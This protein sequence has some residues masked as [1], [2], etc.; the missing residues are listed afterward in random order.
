MILC[1]GEAQ[2]TVYYTTLFGLS[3]LHISYIH[4]SSPQIDDTVIFSTR[5]EPT[6]TDKLQL[7][8][9]RSMTSE[10]LQYTG[11]YY[12]QITSQALIRV[13]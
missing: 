5:D 6:L 10:L 9:I 4:T 8:H 13:R 3:K 12:Y 7:P 1:D 2:L 11:T